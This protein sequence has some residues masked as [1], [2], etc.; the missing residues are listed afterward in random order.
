MA[1]RTYIVSVYHWLIQWR[2][3]QDM[4]VVRVDT[5]SLGRICQVFWNVGMTVVVLGMKRSKLGG[6]AGI[7][8]MACQK[9]PS[10]F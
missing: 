10:I 5:S 3:Y 4:G 1:T 6:P 9:Y 7:C 8:S 2:S